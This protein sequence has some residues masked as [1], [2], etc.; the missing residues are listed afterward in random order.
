MGDSHDS[1]DSLDLLDELD[2][3]IVHALQ[4]DA[5]APWTRIAAAVGA[6]AATVSRHWQRL[7]ARSLAWLTLWPTPQR[8]AA[9]TDVALVLLDTAPATRDALIDLPW[10]L[11]LD[12]TSAGLMATVA[13]SRGLDELGAR[14][15]QLGAD[16]A[17]IRRMHVAGSIVQEDSTWRLA[18]LG[19]DEQRT[20]APHGTPRRALRAPTERAVAE[21]A[22]AL[23][24]DPRLATLPLSRRLG[25]SEPTARRLLERATAAGMLRFGCD[26]A[27]P[28]AGL[29]RGAVLWA[30]AR[31][32]E[33]AADRAARLPQAHRVGILV[34]PAPLYVCVRLHSLAML[35]RVEAAW[36]DAAAVEIAD[37][38]T[39]LRPYK[40][41]GHV[42]DAQGRAIRRV[43]PEW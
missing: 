29:G 36:Q 9:S 34:A 35:P 23:E 8:W 22:A 30:R 18:S 40:R 17:H 27:L 11:G 15:R 5:R 7:Q 43:Q 6:D 19:R 4:L 20:L 16:G 39:I 26:V 1:L 38:W 2:L 13:T 3:R 12:E 31:D 14:V 10:V 32:V 37:R 33:H 42:L 41:N 28:S 25:V 24:D 21:A